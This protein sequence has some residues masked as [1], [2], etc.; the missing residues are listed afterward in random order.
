MFNVKNKALYLFANNYFGNDSNKMSIFD[1][2]VG[3]IK[4]QRKT[5]DY[6]QDIVAGALKEINNMEE[7]SLTEDEKMLVICLAI[8]YTK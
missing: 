8:M 2:V 7:F 3:V 5:T 6:F 4:R 1:R